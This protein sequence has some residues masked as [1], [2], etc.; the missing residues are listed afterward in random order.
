MEN[1]AHYAKALVAIAGTG[2]T[3]ALGLVGPDEPAFMWLTILSAMLTAAA[4]YVVPNAPAKGELA[5]GGPA[6]VDE[7]DETPPPSGYTPEH[8]NP[9]DYSI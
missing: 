1:I 9:D 6:I 5:T 7:V 4:V 8:R 2:V 3:A